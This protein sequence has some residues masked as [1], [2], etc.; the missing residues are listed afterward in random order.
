MGRAMSL[1]GDL[2]PGAYPQQEDGW[3][4]PADFES[5]DGLLVSLRLRFFLFLRRLGLRH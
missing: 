2:W 5:R 1:P 3:K 4:D